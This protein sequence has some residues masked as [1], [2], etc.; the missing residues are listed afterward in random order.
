MIDSEQCVQLAEGRELFAPLVKLKLGLGNSSRTK[1]HLFT[2]NG[3]LSVKTNTGDFKGRADGELWPP[4]ELSMQRVKQLARI[5]REVRGAGEDRPDQGF[6]SDRQHGDQDPLNC[7]GFMSAFPAMRNNW[8]GRL[9]P[10]RISPGTGSTS[11]RASSLRRKLDLSSARPRTRSL[12]SCSSASVKC[13][14]R[15]SRGI[16]S[17][18]ISCRRLAAAAA[19]IEA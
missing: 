11:S 6:A 18:S 15:T 5:L 2:V 8:A 16:S 10:R 17:L 12:N 13:S 14:G 1:C 9:A 19:M 4:V 3:F 7:S